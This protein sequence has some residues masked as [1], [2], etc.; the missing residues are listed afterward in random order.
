M[1][2]P[3]GYVFEDLWLFRRDHGRAP[4]PAPVD[5]LFTDGH[6]ELDLKPT[7]DRFR[8]LLESISPSSVSNPA[9]IKVDSSKGHPTA[10][11]ALDAVN[12][13]KHVERELGYL[14][15]DLVVW[16][17]VAE[18]TFDDFAELWARTRR[19]RLTARGG[20][21]LDGMPPATGRPD[22]LTRGDRLGVARL[23]SQN[24]ECALVRVAQ[25]F[26]H[27]V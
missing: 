19:G 18:T 14:Q 5:M 13:L 2:L 8:S 15:F 9:N 10:D 17:C 21:P 25:V 6:I 24:I 3:N 1:G 26:R 23:F 11:R 7:V 27:S 20:I 4:G 22:Y 16:A 12:M